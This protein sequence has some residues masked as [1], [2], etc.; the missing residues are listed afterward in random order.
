ME[1]V[2]D[3]KGYYGKFGGRFLPET[4]V[5][6]LKQIEESY[7]KFMNDADAQAKLDDL[8]K[9]YAGRPTPIY[10]AENLSNLLDVEIYLKR[11]DLV[12]TG[13]H[14]LNNAL[15]QALLAR[16]MG[17]TRLIAETGAG[18]HG[19]ATATCAALM[20]MECEVFMG[21]VDV[22]RQS[23]NVKRMKLLGT[24]VTPVHSGSR[25]LK[26]AINAAMQDWV[27]TV[28]NTHYILGSVVGAH[29]FPMIVRDFQSVISKEA[30]PQ[31][32]E[33]VGRH[34]DC[35]VASVGGG[36]NAAGIFAK[37]L[38]VEGV[39][40]IGVEAGG[41]SNKDGDHS[42]KLNY[43]RPGIVHG[44]F[45]YILQ[46]EEGNLMPVHSVSAGLDYP[47]VGPEHSY[48]KDIGAAV[49]ETCSDKEALDAFQALCRHEGIIPALE[50]SHALGHIMAQKEKYK[51]QKVL[52]NLSGRGDKDMPII[53]EELGL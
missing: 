33:L 27:A 4:L 53:E 35:V 45:T 18:Q 42:A 28:Q 36:S 38:E 1:R 49:Y 14:K 7:E 29:P 43:G 2:P 12:H 52:V 23:P 40:L 48:L 15:G 17:K 24:K 32:L 10:F 26:D 47:A 19:V 31:F 51:G 30:V 13:A 9:R 20:G 39:K 11:E 3:K 6:A 46:T 41:R 34:P 5:P 44:N 8:L 22:D 16:Y 25:T 37:Y 50:S 21:K